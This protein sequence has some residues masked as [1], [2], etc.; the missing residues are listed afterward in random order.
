MNRLSKKIKG[1]QYARPFV[2]KDGYFWPLEIKWQSQNNSL[3]ELNLM[4][5]TEY[6]QKQIYSALKVPAELIQS[7]GDMLGKRLNDLDK[8]GITSSQA[9]ENLRKALGK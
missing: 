8:S 7:S 2:V 1:K 9:I 3:A 5:S 6:A 4:E